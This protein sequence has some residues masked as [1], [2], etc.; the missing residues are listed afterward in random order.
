[1]LVTTRHHSYRTWVTSSSGHITVGHFALCAFGA[2]PKCREFALG[3]SLALR[4]L[5]VRAGTCCAWTAGGTSS[6]DNL[7]TRQTADAELRV[8]QA[9][10]RSTAAAIRHGLLAWCARAASSF[11]AVHHIWPRTL[12]TCAGDGVVGAHTRLTLRGLRVRTGA[13]CTRGARSSTAVDHLVT[14]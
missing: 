6:I 10:A 12:G 2:L 13:R 8:R 14:R 5:H 9:H 3:T 4:G 7:V 1:M 11:T